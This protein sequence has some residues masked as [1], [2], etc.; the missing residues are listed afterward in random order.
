[1]KV[2][3]QVGGR[4]ITFFNVERITE[5]VSD[6][7]GKDVQGVA[8]NGCIEVKPNT[9]NQKLF[10]KKRENANQEKV[11]QLILEAFEKMKE[12][13][14]YSKNFKIIIPEKTWEEKTIIELKKMA[15]EI[16]DHMT[17][18]VEKALEW[19]QLLTNGK[20]WE[21]ICD[22]ADTANWY[23]LIVWKNGCIRMIGG[24][25]NDKHI[26]PATNIIEGNIYDNYSLRDVVPS[27]TIYEK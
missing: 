25:V 13:P 14:E 9:I 26:F 7:I 12:E 22:N 16:G 19:A 8:E 24:S 5:V 4:E 1:M 11:R 10:Q 20:T 15:N 17:N 23:R 3:L 2:T 6:T 18:W 21:S 27:V